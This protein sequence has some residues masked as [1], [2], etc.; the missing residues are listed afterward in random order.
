MSAVSKP[1]KPTLENT[2]ST[3]VTVRFTH[4]EFV[5]LLN[6]IEFF[7]QK[8]P[9][10]VTKTDTIKFLVKNIDRIIKEDS[11]DTEKFFNILGI[12]HDYKIGRV[13]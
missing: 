13:E 7:Q 10:T 6:V 9:T 5:E 2:K 3:N 11:E 4:D 1:R 12:K 8:T